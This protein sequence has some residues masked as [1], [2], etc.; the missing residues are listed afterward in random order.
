[1]RFVSTY[2]RRTHSPR[3]VTLQLRVYA[4]YNRSRRMLLFLVILFV[5]TFSAMYAISIKIMLK[6]KGTCFRTSTSAETDIIILFT[7]LFV[8]VGDDLYICTPRSLPDIYAEIWVPMLVHEAIL[9]GLA[10][11]KGLQSL[12]SRNS[13]NPSSRLTL[14]L[15]KDSALYFVMYV[16]V[17]G[18]FF[19][20]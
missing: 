13:E 18:C 16:P 20:G 2:S 4:M 19:Y 10:I 3:E 15:V 7:G 8:D 14:F 12:R 6:E 17:L 9:F 5:A 1:M 11:Y